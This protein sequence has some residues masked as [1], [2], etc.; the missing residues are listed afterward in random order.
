MTIRSRIGAS[1]CLQALARSKAP[2]AHAASSRLRAIL[3][4][5][6]LLQVIERGLAAEPQ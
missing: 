2:A 1:G 5:K 4:D 6:D 3:K